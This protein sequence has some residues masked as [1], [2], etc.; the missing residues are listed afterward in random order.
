ME[1]LRSSRTPETVSLRIRG[2]AY[3]LRETDLE[4]G[5]KGGDGYSGLY[6][7]D[8]SDFQV[9]QKTPGERGRSQESFKV[10]IH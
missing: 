6:P 7:K 8:P 9:Q 10:W 1:K 4:G 2:A 5:N 3:A